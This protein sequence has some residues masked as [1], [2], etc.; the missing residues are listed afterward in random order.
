MEMGSGEL[1]YNERAWAIDL[2]SF[3]ASN[4]DL[5]GAIKK[6]SGEY[7]LPAGSR[8]LFP[9][10]LLFGDQSTGKVL[11]GWELKMP[12]TACDDPELISNAETK[13]RIL[14]LN[15]FLVWN[16]TEAWLYVLDSDSDQYC[17]H[18]E[19]LYQN[20]NIST[21]SDVSSHPDLWKEA[22]TQI[23]ERLNS[24]FLS[25][26]IS[27]V[28][29]ELMFSDAGLVGQLLSCQSEVKT[30]IERKLQSDNQVDARIK[31]WWKQVKSQY[32]GE[33]SPTGPLSYCILFRWFNRFVFSNIL[34]AY[35]QPIREL[36]DLDVNV[37]VQEAL[38]IFSRVSE[39]KNYC[40][41]FGKADF[42]DL[43]P[44]SVWDVLVCFNDFLKDFEFGRIDEPVLQSIL[45]STVLTSI[46]KAAGLYVTP[47]PLARLLVLL[48]LSDKA[49]MA[50][51]P[52]CGTGTMIK[53]ILE[54]KSDYNINGREAVQTTWGSDKFAFPVQIS[55]L[56]ISTP[57]HMREP[58]RI[59]THDALTLSA[60]ENISFVNPSNGENIE[61]ETPCF[62]S[63]I[64]NLPFVQF[65]KIPELNR[66]VIEKINEFYDIYSVAPEDCL[67][68]R[69]DLYAYI[70]FLLYNLLDAEGYLGIIVSNSWISASWGE[71][72]RRLLQRFYKLNYVITSANGR[73][74][75]EAKVVTH[76]LICQKKNEIDESSEIK[77]IATKQNIA[78]MDVDEVATDILAENFDSEIVA[79]TPVQ[80]DRLSQIESLNIGWTACFTQ[81]DWFFQY[82][83]K[84]QLLKTYADIIRG[85]RWGRNKFYYPSPNIL[86]EIDEEYL[87][88]LLK[89]PRG[90][91]C[92]NVNSDPVLRALCC[93]RSKEILS[94][95]GHVGTLN[96]IN[97]NEERNDSENWYQITNPSMYS[98]LVLLMNP[99]DLLYC[100]RLDDP[101]I[102]DQR[103]HVVL[104]KNDCDWSLLHALLNSTF[105][106]F[107][108]ESTGFGR[109]DGVLDTRKNIVEAAFQIPRMELI[110]ER[111]SERIKEKF[112]SLLNR[113]ILPVEQELLQPDRIELDNLILNAIGIPNSIRNDICSSLI[114]LYNIRKS[115]GR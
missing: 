80:Q 3:I 103:F 13:A 17:R 22:A 101:A 65:K 87:F 9:D 64:S 110:S 63:I 24:F 60:G 104:P 6:V 76:L 69:S 91:T 40:N 73:W 52:F 26:M 42:D 37:T 25:G 106:M 43:I 41:V 83:N 33:T 32:P 53:A 67:G 61:I 8:N 23:I 31:L 21:R 5:A 49:D 85:E 72:F 109:G 95:L 74:F 27:G 54:V 15:S 46:K 89:S 105:S 14:G 51:D 107:M 102:I 77:F 71:K 68:G 90:N 30:Y 47:E 28:S 88:P 11:Q 38:N 62:S 36:D 112:I 34:K 20:A 108:M 44:E 114:S 78:D 97:Q 16:V 4:I 57:E 70:P 58:M 59:F 81:F 56:A 10:V 115:V 48:S 84:F 66:I 55:T 113:P 29:P 7:T 2:I 98:S 75:T 1:R 79:I 82:L 39:Q 92:L 19:P 86:P 96:W 35:N 45:K 111:N 12:D 100:A 99:N 93:S 50:I 18:T 94:Q